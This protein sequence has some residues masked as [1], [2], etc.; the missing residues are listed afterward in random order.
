VEAG[1]LRRE[2]KMMVGKANHRIHKS[3]G[4]WVTHSVNG[5]YF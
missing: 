3:A 4:S 5:L 2:N 1:S